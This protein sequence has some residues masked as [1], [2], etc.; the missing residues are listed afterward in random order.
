[1]GKSKDQRVVLEDNIIMGCYRTDSDRHIKYEFDE[2]EGI[3]WGSRMNEE[4]K[5]QIRE[6]IKDLCT[7]NG[8]KNFA[9]YQA[10]ID[11]SDGRIWIEKEIHM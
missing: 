10:V 9:F 5:N 3:I 4:E 6:T 1:M 7:K 8:R 2:L 11:P